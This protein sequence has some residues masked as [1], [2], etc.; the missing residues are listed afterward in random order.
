MSDKIYVFTLDGCGHCKY[1]K[2][3]LNELKIP[4]TEIEVTV[5]EHLWEQVV[6]QTGHDSL[7]TVYIQKENQESGPVYVPGRDFDSQEEI[8]EI[9]KNY[10]K[11]D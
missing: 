8:I 10:V 5:N 7:P 1:L 9:L 11:G 6:K 2:M 3:E 4:Y